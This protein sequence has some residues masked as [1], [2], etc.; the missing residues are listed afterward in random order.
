MGKI[1]RIKKKIYLLVFIMLL[2]LT[3]R[4]YAVDMDN[5]KTEKMIFTENKI[6]TI[7]NIHKNSENENIKLIDNNI[8]LDLNTRYLGEDGKLINTIKLINKSKNKE[9]VNLTY[10]LL[11]DYGKI[12]D[13][14]LYEELS[15]MKY[16]EKIIPNISISNE[17]IENFSK[18]DIDKARKNLLDL[19]YQPK[20]IDLNEKVYMYSINEKDLEEDTELINIEIKKDID[21]LLIHTFLTYEDNEESYEFLGNGG[22]FYSLKEPIEEIN[23][24]GQ[25]IEIGDNNIETNKL[26]EK[27]NITINLK[28]EEISLS[29]MID[30]SIPEDLDKAMF[31]KGLD[32]LFEDGNTKDKIYNFDTLYSDL[33]YKKSIVFL[34]Y[35]LDFDGEEIIESTVKNPINKYDENSENI[36][37]KVEFISNP[38]NSWTEGEF[39]FR[40]AINKY[41]PFIQSSN[42]DLKEDREFNYIYK[43][44]DFPKEDI[45]INYGNNTKIDNMKLGYGIYIV[46]IIIGIGIIYIIRKLYYKGI[47]K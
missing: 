5:I 39:N 3:K 15:I 38:V 23:Y 37:M 2:S 9:S 31:L 33:I 40:I 34:D 26:G 14:I 6:D 21:K 17:S 43:S 25:K 29:E 42:I 20:N 22:I 32:K 44:A 30:K 46:V 28:K 7:Y 27:E 41:L 12:K 10:L 18:E 13:N 45:I 4:S 11:D 47:D 1:K 36:S 19:N 8:Y 16:N 24:Q 35:K